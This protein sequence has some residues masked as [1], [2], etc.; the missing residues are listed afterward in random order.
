V[1]LPDLV[2]VTAARTPD[3]TAVVGPDRTL[4]YAELDALAFRVAHAL[5]RHGVAV[6][7]RVGLLA[8][9][10]AALV[11][12]MQ[13]ILRVGAAYVPVD[14][15]QPTVRA[16]TILR[17]C[18]VTAVIAA[19]PHLAE[20][21]GFLALPI[22]SI[23]TW[24][25]GPIAGELTAA[26]ELAYVLYTSGSTGT[27]KGVCISHANALA[28]VEWSAAATGVSADDR[29]A[30]HASFT[31]DLSVFDLYACF[32]VG[33]TL[34]LI[35]ERITGNPR[36]LVE[37]IAERE[38][39]VWYSVP[40]VLS[41]MLRAGGLLAGAATLRVL[42]FAGEPFTVKHLREIMLGLPKARYFN[43]YGP[44]E[45]NVCT[46][47]EVT[48]PPL[49]DDVR[50]PIGTAASGAEL[51]VVGEDGTEVAAGGRGELVVTGPTVMT[52][53]WGR[54][55]RTEPAY[56]TGDVVLRRA[57]GM[58]EFIGRL[59]D[60]VKVRGQRIALGEI[61]SALTTDERID[62]AGVATVGTGLARRL[63]AHLVSS[64][65]PERRPGLLEVKALC[66]GTLPRHMI[67]DLIRYVDEL[68]RTSNGKLDRGELARQTAAPESS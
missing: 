66:A 61:E 13:G 19:E 64:H 55:A 59:D 53:Y 26:G 18:G 62:V 32:L 58:L 30:N 1:R 22:D 4:T 28:F 27:P 42:V 41:L 39:T 68:P 16:M 33:G 57:D 52:G 49:P 17:D 47:Y 46:A 20:L 36:A 34:H 7:D 54:P 15:G 24:S 29:F 8:G 10:S 44:T 25:A 37:F 51:R 11:A 48:T 5:L 50:I 12:C 23:D 6:G 31:F 2:R 56:P 14:P 21:G 38:I 40:S 3:A 65:Q 43:F 45:T 63:V 67:V 60:V 9:K 35:P